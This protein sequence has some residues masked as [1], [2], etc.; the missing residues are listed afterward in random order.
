V[1]EIKKVPVGHA[2]QWFAVILKN[3]EGP[4]DNAVALFLSRP[5]AEQWANENYKGRNRI[6]EVEIP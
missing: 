6:A 4:I 2:Q 3:E 5:T 1:N